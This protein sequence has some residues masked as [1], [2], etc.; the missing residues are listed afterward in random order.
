MTQQNDSQATPAPNPI[1]TIRNRALYILNDGEEMSDLVEAVVTATGAQLFYVLGTKVET[2]TVT[3]GSKATIEK[4]S[5]SGIFKVVRNMVTY[6]ITEVDLSD[7]DLGLGTLRT[8]ASFMLDP[9][10]WALLDKVDVFLRKVFEMHGTEAVVLLSYDKTYLNHENPEQGWG[11]LVP[12]QSNTA[13]SCDYDA[14]TVM[15]AIPDDKTSDIMVVG[16]IHSHP[17]MSAFASHTDHGD[18]M[19]FDGIHITYGWRR[20]G[21]T[22]YHIELQSGGKA[23]EMTPDIAFEPADWFEDRKDIEDWLPLVSKKET[24]TKK[25]STKSKS[26][27][28]SNG[29]NRSARDFSHLPPEVP[30]PDSNTSIVAIV[31]VHSRDLKECPICRLNT[32]NSL[33][34]LGKCHACSSWVL[35]S[36]RPTTEALLRYRSTQNNDYPF[37]YKE[38]DPSQKYHKAFV[39]YDIEEGTVEWLRGEPKDPKA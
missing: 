15:G 7:D 4:T 5:T 21:P 9:I 34:D 8:G 1:G 16:S 30:K 38:L 20:N 18:Q 37:L 24:R 39:L 12:E 25:T 28:G 17:E 13:G 22:E 10:P 2:K 14:T 11:V 19:T 27:P 3:K 23:Y 36:D 35:T 33:Q 26:L 31:D 32:G 6:A 29:W